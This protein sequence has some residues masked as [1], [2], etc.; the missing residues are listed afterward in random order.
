MKIWGVLPETAALYTT[1]SPPAAKAAWKT[2]S[3][4]KFSWRKAIGSGLRPDRQAA[5]SAAAP[6]TAS[7][8]A[9][10][11]GTRRRAARLAGTAI[12][13]AVCEPPPSAIHCSSLRRSLADC[14]RRSGSLARH[15][16]TAR[17]NPGG[18]APP[19]LASGGG[20]RSMIAAISDAGLAAT[21][22]RRPLAISYST[23]PRAQRSLRVSGSRPSSCSGARYCRVPTMA[24]A[25]VSGAAIVGDSRIASPVPLLSPSRPVNPVAHARPKSISLAPDRVSMT[26]P[27][28]RSRC[29]TPARWARSSASATWTPIRSVSDIGSAPRPSRSPRVSPSISSITRYSMASSR[30]TSKSVQMCGWLRLDIVRASASNRARASTFS[31]R[32]GDSTL[33]A[34]SRPRRVSR[35]RYT[36][37]MPPAPRGARIA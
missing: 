1:L 12:G 23:H 27:G 24:P 35:A 2:A 34:T 37:P 20:S 22:G 33:T 31:E 19:G 26:F 3:R 21:K 14:Q 17:S 8:V 6:T 30:P 13:N 36:S 9:R 18:T 32:S 29:T 16:M 5:T 4:R 7:S 15:C 25:A 28:L 11:E 10:A